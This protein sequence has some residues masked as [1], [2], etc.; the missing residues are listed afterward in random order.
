MIDPLSSW[1]SL[2][3]LLPL[4]GD[5]S[6]AD[7]QA[8]FV[9]KRTLTPGLMGLTGQITFTFQEATFANLLKSIPMTPD[10]TQS[11]TMIANAWN[12]AVSTSIMV[13]APGAFIGTSTP[14]TLFS[15]VTSTLLDPSSLLSATQGI[16]SDLSAAPLSDDTSARPKAFYKAFKTL[17]YTVTGTNSIVPTPTPLVAPNLPFI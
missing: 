14:A 9:L 12:S 7:N 15:V 16:V 8:T 10:K 3:N 13:V 2:W 1:I 6:W 17:T 5:S 4:V 11:A